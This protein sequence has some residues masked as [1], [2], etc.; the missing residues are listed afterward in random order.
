[1][2]WLLDQGEVSGE[3][4]GKDAREVGWPLDQGEG[5]EKGKAAAQ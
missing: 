5:G 2:C 3:L 4:P 1:V